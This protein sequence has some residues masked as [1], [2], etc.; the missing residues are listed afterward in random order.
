LAEKTLNQG[1][2]VYKYDIPLGVTI[3]AGTETKIKYR[4]KSN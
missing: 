1:I 4:R 3:K 2:Y